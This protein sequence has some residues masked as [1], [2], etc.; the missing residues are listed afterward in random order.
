MHS[1]LSRGFIFNQPNNVQIILC[2][3]RQLFIVCA[4]NWYTLSYI[5]LYF[6][7]WAFLKVCEV[8]IIFVGNVFSY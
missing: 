8:L 5:A 4:K 7:L 2:L 6:T 3:T 1:I